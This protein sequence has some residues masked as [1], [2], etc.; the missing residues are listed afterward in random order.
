VYDLTGTFLMA[1]LSGILLLV[2]ATVA[3]WRIAERKA[4]GEAAP[5]AEPAP[6]G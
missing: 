3:S 2:V 4:Y 1:L 6:P 5:V